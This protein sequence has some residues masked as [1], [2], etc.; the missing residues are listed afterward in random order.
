M[1]RLIG[2][3]CW[4]GSLCWI[5]SL[6]LAVSGR[7][8]PE[9]VS[10]RASSSAWGC[11]EGSARA[12]Y[13]SFGFSRGHARSV[14]SHGRKVEGVKLSVARGQQRVNKHSRAIWCF[15]VASLVLLLP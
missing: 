11:S 14:H 15:I 5:G 8:E 1:A 9:L 4:T 10:A 2:S 6:C 7:G 3:L 13:L 12:H